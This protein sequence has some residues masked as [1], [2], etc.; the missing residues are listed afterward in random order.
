M[1]L[2]NG[3]NH[4]LFVEMRFEKVERRPLEQTNS[5]D[6]DPRASQECQTATVIGFFHKYL[7][8]IFNRATY[9]GEKRAETFSF[10][11]E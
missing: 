4:S 5:I 8:F 6:T 1:L 2:D 3:D 7:A 9:I 10:R 11:V